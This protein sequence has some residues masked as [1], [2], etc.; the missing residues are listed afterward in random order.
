MGNHPLCQAVRDVGKLLRKRRRVF[1]RYGEAV[2]LHQRQVLALAGELEIR[3]QFRR[4]RD[5]LARR[6]HDQIIAR[7]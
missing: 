2:R 6:K 5:V 7:A 1:V 3:V 4:V